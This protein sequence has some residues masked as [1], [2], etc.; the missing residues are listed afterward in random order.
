M[1]SFRAKIYLELVAQEAVLVT[2]IK[3]NVVFHL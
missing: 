3:S 2:V 1:L